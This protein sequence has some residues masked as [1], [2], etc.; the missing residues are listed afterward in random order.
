MQITSTEPARQWT[1]GYGTGNGR[2]EVLSF[3]V[4]R[5][6]TIVFNEGSI[7]AKNNFRLKE[8]AAEDRMYTMLKHYINSN[9]LDFHHPPFQMDGNFGFTSGEA[10]SQIMKDGF[11][12]ILPAPALA[13]DWEKGSDTSLRTRGGL[14]VALSWE[15]GRV[16]ATTTASRPGKFRFMH[17]KR[18]KDLAMKKGET[19][20]LD[21]QP[22][23]H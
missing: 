21:F 17:Q 15:N 16:R 14:K 7:F 8:G 11:Q 18:K 19:A 9:R 20:Q 12:V 23:A 5:Q 3:G 10:Q 6:E 4:F 2:L 13:N 22:V 1:E